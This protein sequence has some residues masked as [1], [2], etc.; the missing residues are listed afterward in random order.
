MRVL[1]KG[2][3]AGGKQGYVLEHRLV[4]EE[5]LG[6]HLEPHERVHHKNGDRLDNRPEN[7]ELWAHRVQPSGQR[8]ED[9]LAE[10]I[11]RHPEMA[12]RLLA[13]LKIKE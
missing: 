5:M 12:Q 10:L 11:E 9:V 8:V 2:H 3:P 4:M 13:E 7:L 1:R 6:R